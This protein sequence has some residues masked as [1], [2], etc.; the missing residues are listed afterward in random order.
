VI[1]EL[2]MMVK[3]QIKVN[4]KERSIETAPGEMLSEVLRE[5][6]GLIGTKIGCQEMECGSCTV[7]VDGEAILSCGYPA[8]KATGKEIL[9]IEGLAQN[10]KLHPLQDAFVKYGAVQCGFCIPGQIMT[11]AAIISKDPI[12]DDASIRYALK[13]TLCR[14]AGYPT[15]LDSIHAAAHSIKTGTQISEPDIQISEDHPFIGRIIQ[16]PDA[17]EKVTGKALFTD[18]YVFPEM[19]HGRTLRAGVPHAILRSIDVSAAEQTPGVLAVLTAE[20][21]PGENSHGIVIHDWPVLIAVGEKAR[22]VGDALAIVAAETPEIASNALELIEVQLESIPVVKDPVSARNEG[23]SHVHDGGNLLKHIKV[24]KGNIEEGIIAADHV[25][26]D[27]YYTPS[28]E[29]AFLE[30]EC[31]L[32][33]PTDDNRITVYVGSQI[34]YADREQIARSLDRDPKEIRVVGTL[35]GGGFGGKED[36]AGQIHAALLVQATGRPV[37]MLYD[38]HE[39]LLV[40]PKRHATQ[41][42]VR[43]GA[44]RDGTLVFAETEL[45]GDTGAYASLGEK[46]MTRATTH[47]TGPY[48]VPHVKADCFAMYTNNPPAGAFRG[49][50]VTQSAFAIESLVDD[51]AK[52]LEM[53]PIEFRRRNALRVGTVTNT[54][55]LL[56]ESVGL[57]EC[58]DLVEQE[59]RS[60]SNGTDPFTPKVVNGDP[61]LQRAWGVAAAFKNTGLGGGAPD[62]AIAE[63]E[64]FEDGSA[65]L[66]TS[67][68]E[69]GQGLVTVLQ[70]IGAE[71]LQFPY[72]NIRVLLSDTDLTPDGGPT[73]ASRQTYMAGNAVRHACKVLHQGM[74]STLAERYDV[75]PETVRFVEGLAQ[76]QDAFVPVGDVV[77]MMKAEG[78]TPKAKYE[79][80]APETQPLGS[81]GDMHFAYSFAVQAAE[82]EVNLYTGQIIVLQIIAATDVGKAINPLGL[83]G[84]IEGGVMMGL[85]NALTEEF[86]LEDGLIFS[87]RLARYR[88]PSVVHTPEIHSI[89]VEHPT[90]HGPFGAKGVGEISSIPTTPAITNAIYN[91][92]GIRV[93][94]LPVDQDWLALAIS[95][96]DERES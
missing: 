40:H 42:H 30:P 89:I 96:E 17:V 10:G 25:L 14:C 92:C 46:V 39:S 34:P 84:Q 53:D 65:E 54:G 36:I 3:I 47:S 50:G 24:R 23:S 64:L 80:W 62:K 75:P 4:G 37:K 91:A 71:E 66:R 87:D 19:L 59:I 69:I 93:R 61:N 8:V 13:G 94:K 52:S 49:F 2:M 22:Y 38:R 74:V 79:Y 35:I 5:R 63:V 9:T 56:E 83:Q 29:H 78:R 73:T 28:T 51:F 85:G 57:V 12:P 55:Q 26:E 27:S 76:I 1:G 58:L 44:K 88:M 67:S 32:A 21:I 86:I 33:L 15:I 81:G 68:A 90:S 18:D 7:L 31:S 16:R 6:L 95:A 72:E 20:D 70:M 60:S 45:Y 77:G 43:L 41:I 11:A 82:V 48:V